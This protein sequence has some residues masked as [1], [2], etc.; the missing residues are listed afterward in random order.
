MRSVASDS[1][2]TRP[3]TSTNT[4][5]PTPCTRP[6]RRTTSRDRWWPRSPS[7][8][9]T[10]C[11]APGRCSSR[12]RTSRAVCSAHGRR[13][14]RR[15][16]RST[17]RPPRE[18]ELTY[19]LPLRCEAG[20]GD[21]A[22]LRAY[23]E[24]L[25]PVAELIVVDGSPPVAFA[26]HAAW[27]PPGVRHIPPDP[28]LLFANGKVNGVTTGVHAA[29]FEAVVIADD[30]VR[31]RPEQL[32]AIE[33]RLGTADLVIPANAFE[34]PR[35]VPLPWHAR[36]DTA[37]TLLNRATGD[38]FPGTLAVRRSMFRSIG[39]YDGDVLFEN[40]ELIRTV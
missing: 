1:E 32:R 38:D 23:V 15:C 30:D 29:S 3:A 9:R 37:R 17:C 28:A 8:R 20:H 22:D 40:L 26:E 14:G 13:D 24:E 39:G 34:T 5:R 16:G 6:S 4:S 10:C 2:P 35:S 7:S 18:V 25:A 33:Q 11:S 31:Y 27:F 19:L 36:W 12:R 21:H